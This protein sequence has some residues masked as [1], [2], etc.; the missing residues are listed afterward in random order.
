MFTSFHNLLRVFFVLSL[1]IGALKLGRTPFDNSCVQA[2]SSETN[3]LVSKH[4]G[5]GDV[6]L[7]CIIQC[8]ATAYFR[9]LQAIIRS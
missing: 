6:T 5:S 3:A 2:M 8:T 9:I 7:F 4:S 1:D